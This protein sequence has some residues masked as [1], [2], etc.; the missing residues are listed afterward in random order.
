MPSLCAEL[1]QSVGSLFTCDERDGHVRI[2]TPFLYPDGDVIDI[3]AQ[4]GGSV[5]TL[6]DFGETLRWLRMQTAAQRRSTKQQQLIQDV[7]LNHG[8]ELYRGMLTVRVTEPTS[9]SGAVMRLSQAALRVADLWFTFRTR[10]VESIT[11]EVADFLAE[12]HVPFERSD[13]L[14]GRS[15][16][17]WR[18]DFHTR[19]NRRTALINVLSTGSVAAAKGVVEHV[20]TQWHDLSHL[21]LGSEGIRFVSLFDDNVN[22]WS[23]HDLKLLSEF[24]EITYWSRPDDLFAQVV[25]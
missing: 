22:V 5:L 12:R 18:P 23:E 17:V 16:R 19:T 3:Y 10:A 8:V 7:L 15:G 11:D 4:N 20:F 6:S 1:T 24:S 13:Q 2:R 21:K 25:A 9:L 14:L